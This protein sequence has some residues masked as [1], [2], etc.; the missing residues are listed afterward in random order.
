LLNNTRI[1]KYKVHRGSNTFFYYL[2]FGSIHKC[3]RSSH[4]KGFI[5]NPRDMIMSSEAR[6]SNQPCLV[7]YL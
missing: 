2:L 1:N 6:N 5:S 4:F 3:L 7:I